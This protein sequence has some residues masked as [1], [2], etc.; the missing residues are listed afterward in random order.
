M[1][2]GSYNSW[3]TIRCSNHNLS[4]SLCIKHLKIKGTRNYYF[5]TIGYCFRTKVKSPLILRMSYATW[6][7]TVNCTM[8]KQITHHQHHCHFF[9]AKLSFSILQ[10]SSFAV[11]NTGVYLR[12]AGSKC[13]LLFLDYKVDKQK[14]QR[15]QIVFL[16]VSSGLFNFRYTDINL[17]GSK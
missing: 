14:G 4:G 2:Q 15:G 1:T 13:N 6:P 5:K 16:L 10:A 9:G 11:S 12:Q 17:T 8:N 7:Q 3:P